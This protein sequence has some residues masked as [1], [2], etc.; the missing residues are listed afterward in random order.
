MQAVILDILMILPA[1]LE[2]V[3][4]FRDGVGFQ[5]TIVCYNTV[6]LYLVACVLFGIGSCLLGK[7]PRLPLVADA[8]EAQVPF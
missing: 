5:I 3:F 2:R 6:F 1:L 7:N 8:A 4:T